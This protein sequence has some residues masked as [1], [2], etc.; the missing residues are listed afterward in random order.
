MTGSQACSALCLLEDLVFGP[1]YPYVGLVALT[2]VSE[3]TVTFTTTPENSLGEGVISFL[4]LFANE[5]GENQ[6]DRDVSW[7][8]LWPVSALACRSMISPRHSHPKFCIALHKARSCEQRG[9]G[10]NLNLMALCVYANT[11]NVSDVPGLIKPKQFQHVQKSAITSMARKIRDQWV[12]SVR[13]LVACVLPTTLFGPTTFFGPKHRFGNM[14]DRARYR[15]SVQAV[16]GSDPNISSMWCGLD[17]MFLLPPSWRLPIRT[18]GICMECKHPASMMLSVLWA[19]C[20]FAIMAGC[21]AT[22]H[23]QL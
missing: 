23:A 18:H 11:F 10:E 13:A 9:Q 5:Q 2:F 15:S 20:A 22:N 8:S 16:V 21:S 14:T 3:P 19:T 7:F 1:G 17:N 4:P 12:R 6:F